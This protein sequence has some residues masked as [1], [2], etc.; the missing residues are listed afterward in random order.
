M[1]IF[2]CRLFFMFMLCVIFD[3]RD[4]KVDKIR[5][6][7]SLA[8]AVSTKKIHGIMLFSFVAFLLAGIRAGNFGHSLSMVIS[9]LA[10]LLI[11]KLSLQKRGYFFYYFAVDGMML[12]SALTTFMATI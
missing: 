12:F 5:S 3:S 2:L 11:Y 1:L 8:T 4:V 7:S 6:L 10:V 9:G